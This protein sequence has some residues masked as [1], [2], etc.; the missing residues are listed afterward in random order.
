MLWAV[1]DYTLLTFCD[2][3]PF[4]VAVADPLSWFAALSRMRSAGMLCRNYAARGAASLN[5]H[6]VAD[7]I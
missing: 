4:G 3:T 6:P 5:R 2:G 7:G 1:A